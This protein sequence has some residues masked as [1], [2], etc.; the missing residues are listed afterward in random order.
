MNWN[1]RFYR[2]GGDNGG[3]VVLAGD[4]A[5]T[6]MPIIEIASYKKSYRIELRYVPATEQ[7]YMYAVLEHTKKS[8]VARFRKLA[9]KY[10]ASKAAKAALK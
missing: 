6:R 8:P 4:I 7:R 3:H 1:L 10:G 9:A 5:R 2:P